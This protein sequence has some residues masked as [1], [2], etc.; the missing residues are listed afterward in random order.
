MCLPLAKTKTSQGN[1][2]SKAENY[3]GGPGGDYLL[4]V[5]AGQ[6]PAGNVRRYTKANA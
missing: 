2:I 5:G 4:L 3:Y 1:R 6:S